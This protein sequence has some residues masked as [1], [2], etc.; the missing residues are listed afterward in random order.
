MLPRFGPADALP[1]AR[2]LRERGQLVAFDPSWDPAGWTAETRAGTLALLS[3]ID[4]YLPNEPELLHLT[5]AADLDSAVTQVAALAGEV[6]VKRGAGGALYARGDVRIA[7]PGFPVEAVNT[8]GAG[9]V[10]DAAYLYARRQ[11]WPPEQRLCYANAL[12]AMVVSQRGTR[13]YP[14]A[15]AVDAFIA[16]HAVDE[17]VLVGGQHDAAC[18]H[19]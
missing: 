13:V 14:D 16:T 3:E 18:A 11:G 10:F 8:I 19:A 4:V 9:D 1:Y 15:D 7:V 17:P 6:V 12:A 5:G 2:K